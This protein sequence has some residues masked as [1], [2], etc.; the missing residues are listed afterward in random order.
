[1]GGTWEA[2]GG[3]STLGKPSHRQNLLRWPLHRYSCAVLSHSVVCLVSCVWLFGTSCSVACQAPL[4]MGFSRQEYWSGLP[5]PPPGDLPN[6]GIKPRSPALQ[7]DSLP[8]ELPGKPMHGLC[9]DILRGSSFPVSCRR[10]SADT[11]FM[12]GVFICLKH[13]LKF[14]MRHFR[15]SLMLWLT[16]I[17]FSLARVESDGPTERS[18]L[19]PTSGTC[20]SPWASLWSTRTQRPCAGSSLLSAQTEAQNHCVPD[21][22]M[23]CPFLPLTKNHTFLPLSF[24]HWE[25]ISQYGLGSIFQLQIF[26]MGWNMKQN[27]ILWDCQYQLLF[28]LTE[29]RKERKKEGRKGKREGRREVKKERRK[30]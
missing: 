5:C 14:Q 18:S 28:H 25:P 9:I 24:Y 19:L 29:G 8:S 11:I 23:G 22:R 10:V 20:G 3:L 21:S 12:S 30:A 1:M 27:Q 4:S 2:A 6:P 26:D 13:S 15:K 7:A 17:S 16:F